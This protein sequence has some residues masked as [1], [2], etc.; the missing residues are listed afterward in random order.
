MRSRGYWVIRFS[1]FALVGIV[2][3][4]N[5]PGQPH[6]PHQRDQSVDV[7]IQI[8]CFAVVGLA[9]VAWLLADEF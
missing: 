8:A 5:P 1:G 7:A 4:L 9:L 6:Q 3:L 2:A